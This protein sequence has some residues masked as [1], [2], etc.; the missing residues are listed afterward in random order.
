MSSVLFSNKFTLKNAAR[1]IKDAY[2]L[3]DPINTITSFYR[4][5]CYEKEEIV[6]YDVESNRWVMKDKTHSIAKYTSPVM[7]PSPI[8]KKYFKNQIEVKMP[9]TDIKLPF[10]KD[11]A[12]KFQR[13]MADKVLSGSKIMDA[14][15]DARVDLNMRNYTVLTL[16]DFYYEINKQYGSIV[17]WDKHTKSWSRIDQRIAAPTKEVVKG[18]DTIPTSIKDTV[19]G[20]TLDL[21]KATRGNDLAYLE[22]KLGVAEIRI[23]FNT[24]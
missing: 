7:R 2:G 14:F 15:G 22:I 12:L 8:V 1:Y 17:K 9:R 23:Q 18:S 20:E 10:S 19:Q 5:Y 24:D 11:H 6:I 21:S 3:K 4:R 16:K 13:Y